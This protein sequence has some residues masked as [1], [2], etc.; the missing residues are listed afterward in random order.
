MTAIPEL[1]V[2]S[3][4]PGKIREIKY[5]LNDLAGRILSL[6]EAGIFISPEENGATYLENATIK[7]RAAAEHWPGWILADDSGLEV[8]A[9]GGGPGIYSSRFAGENATD[10][11]NNTKLIHALEDIPEAKRTARFRCVAVLFH[12]ES[13][14]TFTAEGVCEGL[15]IQSLRGKNGFGFDPLF[16]LPSLHRTMA[17]L[18][19]EEKMQISHR[20][21]ALKNLREKIK[22]LIT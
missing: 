20:A 10:A 3:N 8:D 11:E 17:E 9:L 16:F 4:N 14:Q 1:L 5:A 12:G 6:K 2:A 7:A 19:F 22:S 13:G 15:I 21:L 18:T